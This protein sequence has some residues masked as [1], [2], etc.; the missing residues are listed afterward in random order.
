MLHNPF[1]LKGTNEKPA[2]SAP[3]RTLHLWQMTSLTE[4]PATAVRTPQDCIYDYTNRKI[5]HLNLICAFLCVFRCTLG[6]TGF[7]D[8]ENIGGSLESLSSPGKHNPLLVWHNFSFTCIWQP[9]K[10][11][12]VWFP[13]SCLSALWECKIEAPGN[14]RLP[15]TA[16]SLTLSSDDLDEELGLLLPFYASINRI[17]LRSS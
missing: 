10:D 13:A 3:C 5:L 17:A 12:N 8:S 14:R 4:D 16:S 1:Y 9:C 2:I 7:S 15:K 6:K 11:K